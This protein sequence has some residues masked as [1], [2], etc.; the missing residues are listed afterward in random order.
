MSSTDNSTCQNAGNCFSGIIIHLL[1]PASVQTKM[2]DRFMPSKITGVAAIKQPLSVTPEYFASKSFNTIGWAPK[3]DGCFAH[4]VTATVIAVA[5][6][7]LVDGYMMDIFM[8]NFR[9]AR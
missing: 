6:K 3:A 7:F 4:W 9:K 2:L 8:P 1:E 5:P